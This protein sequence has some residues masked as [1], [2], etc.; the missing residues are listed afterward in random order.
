MKKI[1]KNF[2]RK[3]S[4]AETLLEVMIAVFV[5]ALG[6]ATASSLI[7]QSLLSNQYNKDSLQALNLAQEGLEMMR[8]VRNTNWMKFSADTD[9]CWNVRP[10]EATCDAPTNLIDEG[11]YALGYTLS[12]VNP[13]DLNVYDGI[14]ANDETYLLSYY[15]YLPTADADGDTVIDNDRE[16]V[17]SNG[18]GGSAIALDDGVPV[19][20]K[21]YRSVRVIYKTANDV[22]GE[23]VDPSAPVK[24]N[25]NIMMIISKVQWRVQG[26]QS[27]QIILSSALSKYK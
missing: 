19:N 3:K 2:W 24:E 16:F 12:T 5:V 9:N 18:P 15:D 17:G 22:D 6:S 14:S 20:T 4:K 13:V 26:G 27:H 23:L 7:V 10:N 8:V 21:F 1:F 11:F 25:G